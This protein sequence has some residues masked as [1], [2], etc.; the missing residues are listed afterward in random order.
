MDPQLENLICEGIGTFTLPD[1]MTQEEADR[2]IAEA[3]Q[4]RNN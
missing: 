3:E 2:L 1:G 4:D